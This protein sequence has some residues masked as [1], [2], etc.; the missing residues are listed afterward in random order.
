[1]MWCAWR[2]FALGLV[3][4][5][6]VAHG[7]AAEADIPTPY[8]PSTP[9]NVDEM[10]RLATVTPTDTVYDLG[11]GDGR[12][13]I[14]AARDYGAR[15]V[16]IELDRDLVARST[17]NAREAGVAEQAVFRTGDV[18]TADIKDA[19]VVTMYL[20]PP[21]VRRLQER[22]YGELRPGTRIVAHDYPFPDWQA[23][24]RI[25]VS[26]TFYLYTVPARVA[27][28]WQLMTLDAASS[29]SYELR[30]EQRY[31]DV[32]GA[33][34]VPGGILPAFEARMEGERIAFILIDGDHSYRY[35]GVVRGGRI[36]GTVRWGYGPRQQTGQWQAVRLAQ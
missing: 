12:V 18:L 26:K 5:A 14:A 27:G 36:E 16:G 17:E 13:V 8:V 33:A 4:A 19:S 23:D 20:L 25:V 1:M 2:H 24:K 15:G 28:T 30:L 11:S 7:Y 10:L 34:R 3:L 31:Q 32:K 22:L 6:S 35:E 9:L 29:R 21:L